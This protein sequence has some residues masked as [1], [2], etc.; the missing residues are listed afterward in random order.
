MGF[1]FT[2]GK[3]E[4]IYNGDGYYA[5]EKCH[6]VRVRPAHEDISPELVHRDDWDCNSG[7][8]RNPSYSGW[9][10]ILD[11]A[12]KFKELFYS[13]EKLVRET[14]ECG[15]YYTFT[16]PCR[17]Y[18]DKLDELEEEAKTV[19]DNAAARILWFVRWSRK[20]LE[21]Y[22]DMAAFETPG[23]FF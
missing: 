7:A 8:D 12:P 23:E 10:Y 5:N 15:D 19:P 4:L 17:V 13:L 9:S 18:E 16:I 14:R 3:A 11:H 6:F 2:I 1:N 22:G 21:L 20:A